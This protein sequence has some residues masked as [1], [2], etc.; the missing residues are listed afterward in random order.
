MTD[1]TPPYDERAP[2]ANYAQRPT[3]FVDSRRHSQRVRFLRR[4]IVI[5]CISVVALIGFVLAFDPLNR[6]QLGFSIA[7]VGLSG[8]RITMERPRLSGWRNDGQP[9]EI[10]AKA[11][12]QDTT[13]PKVFELQEVDARLGSADGSTTRI[14]A[15]R[16]VYDAGPD[17]LDLT[18]PIRVLSDRRYD[19]SLERAAVDLRAGKVVSNTP[20]VVRLPGAEIEGAGA[21]FVETER[22]VTFEGGVRSIFSIADNDPAGASAPGESGTGQTQ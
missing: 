7:R 19:M 8:T 11:V 5:T 18:G 15:A 3:A 12:V 10:R 13:R 9:Y 22:T 1:V 14:E 17:S 6:L 4:A 16:G 2:F 21:P 20:V